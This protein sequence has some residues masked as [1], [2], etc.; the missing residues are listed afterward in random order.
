MK[1]TKY[2]FSRKN[3]YER[4]SKVNEAS[5]NGRKR[6]S[7]KG[8]SQL[9]PDSLIKKAAPLPKTSVLQWRKFDKLPIDERLKGR[10]AKKAQF[11]TLILVPTRE[12]AL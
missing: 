3:K 12:L 4:S 2:G 7:G 8:Q 11:Q 5:R 9:D 1:S 10:I 6:N